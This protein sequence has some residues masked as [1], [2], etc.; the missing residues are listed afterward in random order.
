MAEYGWYLVLVVA[1]FVAG[2]VNTIA[3]GGSFLTIPALMFICDLSPLIANGTNRIAILFSSAVASLTFR[4]HGNLDLKLA[5]QLTVP[6]ICG[7]PL[8]A[9]LAIWLPADA[10]RP[11][12]GLI[13]LGMSAVLIYD[14]K[15]LV[16]KEKKDHQRSK[17]VVFGVFFAIGV[18][19]G[20]IQAGMGILLLIG[21]SFLRSGDLLSANGVKNLVGF[22]V[23]LAATSFFVFNGLIDWGPGLTAAVGNIAGGYVGAKLALKKGNR[24]IFAFMVIVMVATGIKLVWP[25]VSSLVTMATE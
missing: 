24:L 21:M 16:A 2:I 3:G 10:F 8:G 11:I 20:F 22:L 17:I 25:S 18:Y 14:P 12:F 9:G 23:T 15:R 1:G 6:T 13:F 5:Q 4:K 7:V 19:V